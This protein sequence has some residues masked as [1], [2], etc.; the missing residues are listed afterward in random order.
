MYGMRELCGCN[1]DEN[2]LLT[3]STTLSLPKHTARN[4][5]WSV[6]VFREWMYARNTA[7]KCLDNILERPEV[8][9]LDFGLNRIVAKVHR[10]TFARPCRCCIIGT[11]C[12]LS[13]PLH[14][15]LAPLHEHQ[16]LRS[17][18]KTSLGTY[19]LAAPLGA[20]TAASFSSSLH[21]LSKNGT[22]SR[23]S[24]VQDS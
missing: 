17:R 19:A 16:H 13:V 8:S 23:T 20:R 18:T 21:E 5:K 4:T 3:E 1:D 22:H 2:K 14:L 7:N 10:S 24:M 9:I 15:P 11:V 12:L 6:T